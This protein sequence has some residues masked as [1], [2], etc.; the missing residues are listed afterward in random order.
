[1]ERV[2]L[3]GLS[4]HLEDFEVG[5]TLRL[6]SLEARLASMETNL[7]FIKE[8]LL[9]MARIAESNTDVDAPVK[10]EPARP[11]GS[12]IDPRLV[13]TRLGLTRAQSEVAALLAEGHS[14]RSIAAKVR[15]RLPT[16]RWHL[17][18]INRKLNIQRQSQLVRLV[19]LL[20]CGNGLED[21]KD[22]KEPEDTG[23][24]N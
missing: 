20:P 14:V 22:L 6:D 4:Q 24:T 21:E 16:V 15:C 7:A 17:K 9:T 12:R 19:L 23:E 13:A 3:A 11:G 2:T 5:L 10:E 18:E 8:Q 1:M